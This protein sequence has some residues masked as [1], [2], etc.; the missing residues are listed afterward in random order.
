ME[1]INKIELA[2]TIGTVRINTVGNNHK[3]GRFSV[4]TNYTYKA[5]DGSVICEATWHSVVYWAKHGQDLS[6]FIKG[7]K[8][9][10]LGRLKQSRYTTVD[11]EE[12]SSYEVLAH[13]FEIAEL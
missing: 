7:T 4:A 12:R 5:Q 8:V 9:H 1:N 2:G 13:T 11:G 6:E 10:V 3:V